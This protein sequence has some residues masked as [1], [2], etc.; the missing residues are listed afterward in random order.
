MIDETGQ[1][2]YKS[3]CLPGHSYFK[4]HYKMIAIEL[5]K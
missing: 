1:D 5:S 2:V 3:G 4:E